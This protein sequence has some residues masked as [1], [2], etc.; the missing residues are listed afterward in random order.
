MKQQENRA[1]SSTIFCVIPP[2]AIVVQRFRTFENLCESYLSEQAVLSRFRESNSGLSRFLDKIYHTEKEEFISSKL[3]RSEAIL[4][5]HHTGKNNLQVLL[6]VNHIH[7]VDGEDIIKNFFE[8]IGSVT[9]YK[10]YNKIDVYQL[11]EASSV[12]YVSVIDG[13]LL[14]GTSPVMVESSI[15]HLISGRSLMDDQSFE[16]L[17][18]LSSVTS[19][20]NVYVNIRQLD[21]L[22]GSL[23]SKQM[24]RFTD[25]FTKTASWITLSGATY[26]NYV[27]MNGYV[28]VDHGDA[29]YFS[30]FTNQ[31]PTQVK[32][33]E[34]VPA[35]TLAFI[36]LSPSDFTPYRNQYSNFLEIH[37][38]NRGVNALVKTWETK[39]KLNLNEWFT[40]LN[41]VEVALARIPVKGDYQWVTLV[42]THSVQQVR[43]FLG[44]PSLDSKQLPPVLPN[45]ATGAFSA[46]FGAFFEKSSESHYTILDNTL[47]FG[48]KELLESLIAGY[49]KTTSLYNTMRQ[50]GLRGKWID[51]SGF[52]CVLQ[53]TEVR[54][55]ILHLWEPR[56]DPLIEKALSPNENA[57]VIFQVSPVGGKL[58]THLAF[59]VDTKGSTSSKNARDNEPIR[60]NIGSFR[61]FN[62]ASRKYETLIQE[63]DSTLLLKDITGKQ[64]WRTRR[65]Y[66]I[67]DQ[68]AQIDYLKN[69]KLQMLFVSG[70]T[71]LCLL[72]I[73]GRM[74][75]PY[76]IKL[77]TPVRKGPFVF[78]PHSN[79]E[80]Q[81][82]MIHTDN[83]LRLYDRSGVAVPEWKPFFPDERMEA[84][85]KLLS[86]SGGYYWLVWGAIKDYILKPDGSIAVML[87]K[88]NRIKQDADLKI[89]TQG[90]L[91]G[92]TTEGQIITIQLN[93]GTIK[94][95]KP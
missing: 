56:F 34:S 54:N 57:M 22:C 58:Q 74:T 45:E 33:W 82:F 26:S 9:F 31:T 25:F 14:A 94:T 70:G 3:S 84:A 67:V 23:L 13:F 60:M 71:E 68:V 44:F 49:G 19:E 73:L 30:S 81:M 39:T 53:T 72:D 62:H 90:V 28:I 87:Q 66:A 27:S 48:S 95:R 40:S 80:Y 29:D 18:T 6:G 83:S 92:I 51:E 10:Q 61:I 93:T 86:Y 64:N 1:V 78:D 89:D 7:F 42:R 21:K 79:K 38:R 69:D 50:G 17:S 35:S 4:S 59:S 85:P 16:S 75:S 91:S 2:D 88:Q 76:P 32:L 47:Y 12:L 52:T 77:E 63:P 65:K 8:K 15:R 37:K 36:S 20:S 41:P 55:S 24:Q 11:Y 5:V 43:K 46:L